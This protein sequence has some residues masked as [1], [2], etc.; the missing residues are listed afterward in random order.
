[1]VWFLAVLI[2]VLLAIFSVAFRKFLAVI[3]VIAGILVCVAL[4]AFWVYSE[5][6]KR[7]DEIARSRISI[8]EVELV[9]LGLRG[10]ELSGKIKNKSAKYTLREMELRVTIEDCVEQD[11]EIV[12][13][14]NESVWVEVPPGQVRYFEEYVSLPKRGEP[15]GETRWNYEVLSIKGE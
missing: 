5:R 2:V 12:G 3:G 10:N 9:D 15:R 13:Q 7:E 11:C 6:Q 1:M 4:V 8:P 14:S